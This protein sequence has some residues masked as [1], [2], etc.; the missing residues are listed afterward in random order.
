M[1]EVRLAEGSGFWVS[2]Q[3]LVIPDTWPAQR[4]RARM[5]PVRAWGKRGGDVY[6]SGLRLTQSLNC[7]GLDGGHQEGPR[8]VDKLVSSL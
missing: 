1:I 8:E 2:C 3:N 6:L 5:R 4:C 7:V